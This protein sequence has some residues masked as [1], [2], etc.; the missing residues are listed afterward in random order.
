MIRSNPVI[1]GGVAEAHTRSLGLQRSW[2]PTIAEPSVPL[3]V[4]LLPQVMSAN[5][6]A[7]TEQPSGETRGRRMLVRLV[8]EPQASMICRTTIP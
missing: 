8:G 3:F 5:G 6:A 2:C 1:D 4:L 7:T